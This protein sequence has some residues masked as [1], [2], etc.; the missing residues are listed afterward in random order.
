MADDA[1]AEEVCLRMLA[2]LPAPST[3]CAPGLQELASKVVSQ[4]KS[5]ELRLS[6]LPQQVTVAV[7]ETP[8]ETREVTASVPADGAGP[9]TVTEVV[10]VDELEDPGAA[11]VQDAV[12]QAAQQAPESLVTEVEAVAPAD[13][14]MGDQPGAVTEVTE[15]VTINDGPAVTKTT[16]ATTDADGDTT[17]VRVSASLS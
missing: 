5:L 2:K 4:C 12:L 1:G 6:H 8:T 15:T 10:T 11:A 9:A 7:E 14:E 3:L 13:T 17:V 16:V